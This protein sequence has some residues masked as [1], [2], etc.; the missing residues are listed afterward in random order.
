MSDDENR[1]SMNKL[2]RIL[3]HPLFLLF[4]IITLFAVIIIFV[5]LQL[6]PALSVPDIVNFFIIFLNLIATYALTLVSLRL[7]KI[8]Q[9]R[10]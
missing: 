3:V 7:L 8:E 1:I 2:M 9:K 5:L 10:D 4:I 6:V